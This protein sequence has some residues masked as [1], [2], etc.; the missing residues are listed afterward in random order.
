MPENGR[1]RADDHAISYRRVPFAALTTSA[2]QRNSL[3]NQHVIPDLCRLADHDT[4][5]V[6]NKKPLADF[7]AGMDF[8]AG[9]EAGD[10]GDQPRRDVQLPVVEPVRDLVK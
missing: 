6:V 7:R 2:T 4:Q 9:Q 10:M 8:D 3:I 5:P 1:A